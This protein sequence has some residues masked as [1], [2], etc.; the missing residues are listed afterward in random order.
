MDRISN[1]VAFTTAP[2]YD[3]EFSENV[4]QDLAQ[5]QASVYNLPALS[6]SAQSLEGSHNPLK[7]P[8]R[9][10]IVSNA[11]AM[12]ELARTQSGNNSPIDDLDIFS[13]ESPTHRSMPEFMSDSFYLVDRPGGLHSPVEVEGNHG[14]MAHMASNNPLTQY[15][16]GEMERPPLEG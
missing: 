1:P 10:G 12:E 6:G 14:S 11:A 3:S 5:A 16:R 2:L 8:P 7:Q 4:R 9:E 15:S 13:S